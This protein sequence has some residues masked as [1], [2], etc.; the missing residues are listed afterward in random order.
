MSEA[1]LDTNLL[2]PQLVVENA[3]PP[4]ELF[5]N[6]RSHDPVHWNPPTPTYTAEDIP[7]WFMKEGFWVLTRYDDVFHVSRTPALFSSYAKGPIIWDMEEQELETQRAGMMGMDPPQHTQFK[8][9]VLGPL[10]GKSLQAFE[11]EIARA[12]T[13]II[14][15]ISMAGHCEFVFD[16][17]SKLPVYTFCVMMGIPEE[18]RETIFTLGNQAADQE[19]RAQQDQDPFP[20]LAM[21]A[22]RLAEQKREQPDDS[23]LSRY[24]NGELDGERLTIEQICMFFVTIAIAGHETTRNTTVHFLRLMREYPDQ[25]ELLMSD[26]DKHLPNAI[27]EVLRFAPPVMNFK[28]TAL[29]DTEVGGQA[30]NAGDKLCLSYPAANRDPSMFEAP[31][32]FDITRENARKHLSFG[33]GVHVCLGAQLAR[34]QLKLLL[35]QIYTRIPDYRLVGPP[36]QLNNLMFNAIMRMPIEFTPES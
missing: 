25:C 16:V 35:L 15:D 30:V 33:T 23:M 11:P 9:L 10:M 36:V 5:A 14:D 27:E 21:H 20:A 17:A 31:D 18:D 26:L 28:R 32:V 8:R 2:N 22:A 7:G 29:E 12:A 34:L 13:E 24:V 6:W 3:G 4:Y 1:V 19:N